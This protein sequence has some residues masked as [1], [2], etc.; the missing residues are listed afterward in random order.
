MDTIFA[1]AS[2][3]GKAGVA[4]VRLSGP[5]AHDA[6]A[7][8]AGSLPEPRRASVR[9][10]TGADGTHLDEALVLLFPEGS[11]SRDGSSR[12][13][14][15]GIGFLAVKSRAPVIPV[16]IHGTERALGRGCRLLRPAKVRIYFGKAIQPEHG[17]SAKNYEAI[18]DRVMQQI[19]RLKQ[20]TSIGQRA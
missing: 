15:P 17:S 16:F 19:N 18:A 4:V 13:A 3:R 7:G 9:R 11:R 5:L 14:Q 20:K 12:E 2:G 1:L 8:L 10:L 6:V